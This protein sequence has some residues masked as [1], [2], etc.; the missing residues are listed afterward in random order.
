[1][2]NK[3]Y[4]PHCG[5]KQTSSAKTCLNC[6]KDITRQGKQKSD[7]WLMRNISKVRT[8]IILILAA[9]VI[10]LILVD[11][12]YVENGR[13]ENL[14]FTSGC[15]LIILFSV[16]LV[17]LIALGNRNYEDSSEELSDYKSKNTNTFLK[18]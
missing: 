9:L 10:Y 16:F 2:K 7:S 13:L 1:M 6:G 12:F 3:G 17:I 4:C 18:K 15:V 14:F 5:A 11:K 8:A